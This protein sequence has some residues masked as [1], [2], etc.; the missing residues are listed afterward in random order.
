MSRVNLA[1]MLFYVAVVTGCGSAFPDAEMSVATK[2]DQHTSF[3]AEYFPGSVADSAEN[4]DSNF[5][6]QTGSPPPAKTAAARTRKIIHNCQI[7]LVVDDYKQ[8]ESRLP[9]M[10]AD[11]GGFVASNDTDRRYLDNQSGTWT[12]RIPVSQYAAFLNGVNSLG[13]AESRTENAQD[14]TEEFVDTEARVKTKRQLES[15]ILKMLDERTGKLADVLEIERE[16][17]R[18]REEVERMEG[19]IRYLKD[20]TSLATVTIRCRE[21]QE[22][23]PAAAPTLASRISQSWTDSITSIRQLGETVLVCV[24]AVFPWLFI[25]SIFVA[26]IYYTR[27]HFWFGRKAT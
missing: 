24:I 14:V 10:V 11:Y 15:R 12:V 23:T 19:R 6:S 22:Y 9:T 18:V 16:L 5:A 4:S 3:E 2:S 20:R 17:A 26:V 8:F 27:K 21:E 13:F 25:L 1:M 7:G